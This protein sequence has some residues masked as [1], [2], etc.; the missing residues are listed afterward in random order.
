MHPNYLLTLNSVTV[1][2]D[3]QTK[4]FTKDQPEYQRAVDLIKSEQVDKLG[5]L[6]NETKEKVEKA[7]AP[8]GFEVR[9]G[10]VFVNGEDLPVSLSRYIINFAEQN[11]PVK[12]ILK[13]WERLRNNPSYHSVQRLFECLEHNHHPICEDGRFLGWKCIRSDW[14]DK[15][16]G[17]FDNSVGSD[18]SVPRNRVD[19]NHD[20]DCSY[21]LH[22][23]SYNYASQVFY[24]PGNRVIEVLVD[25][26]DVVSVPNDYGFQ[27]M[28]ICKYH[29]VR[30]C[31]QEQTAHLVDQQT[32]PYVGPN[33][34]GEYHQNEDD[35]CNDE[36]EEDDSHPVGCQGDSDYDDEDMEPRFCEYCGKEL[37][38]C[39]C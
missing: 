14:T 20:V 35:S 15:R 29:V 24:G 12:P 33:N 21:G 22:V 34:C 30:E 3:G 1:N 38:D 16:T 8:Q 5:D 9:D 11:L 6:L 18:P 39:E 19:D 4:V 36:C 10:V 7:Y 26:A 28:R 17:T 32:R 13:F 2:H 23:S 25:P 31:Q 27:K 37:E